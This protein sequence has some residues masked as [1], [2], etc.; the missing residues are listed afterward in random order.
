MQKKELKH[1]LNQYHI[2]INQKNK[3]ILPRW[4]INLN[5]YF[6]LIDNNCDELIKDIVKLSFRKGIKDKKILS[7]LPITEASYYRI[8]KDI[9]NFIFEL[10]ILDGYV[11]EEEIIESFQ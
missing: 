3:A 6:D 9:L 10:F 1:Y 7:I 8:K 5:T 4:F 11:S 2:F